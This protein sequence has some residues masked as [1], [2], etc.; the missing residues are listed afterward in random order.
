MSW[1]YFDGAAQ[2]QGYGGSILF[3]L[4]ETH[5]FQISMGLGRE[6]TT[7]LN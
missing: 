5:Y 1:A 7:M 4:Y 3:H 6:Q 2:Q